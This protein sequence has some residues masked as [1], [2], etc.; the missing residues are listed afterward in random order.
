MEVSPRFDIIAGYRLIRKLGVGERSEVFLGHALDPGVSP[1]TG[2]AGVAVKVFRPQVESD[3]ID[4][5]IRARVAV[6]GDGLA[7]KSVV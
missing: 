6:G 3:S 7:G 5:E 1:S 4:R 2:P